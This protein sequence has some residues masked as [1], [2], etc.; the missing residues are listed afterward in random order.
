MA[1]RGKSKS[2]RSTAVQYEMKIKQKVKSQ[3]AE[4]VKSMQQQAENLSSMMEKEKGS[5]GLNLLL[6]RQRMKLMMRK[7]G[8]GD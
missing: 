7:Y 1:R 5:S 6:Q 4:E 3:Y 2:K 8:K